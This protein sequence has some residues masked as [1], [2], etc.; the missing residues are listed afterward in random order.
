MTTGG[1]CWR[2]EPEESR[3]DFET[4]AEA[5]K[6]KLMAKEDEIRAYRHT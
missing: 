4:S 3:D 2:D 1:K 6:A 5:S